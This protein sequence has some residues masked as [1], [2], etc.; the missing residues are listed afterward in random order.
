MNTHNVGVKND[1]KNL[2]LKNDKMTPK[3]LE[4]R[5]DPYIFTL[6]ETLVCVLQELSKSEAHV[7]RVRCVAWSPDSLR[8]VTGALDSN[9]ILWDD[10]N[11][12]YKSRPSIKGQFSAQSKVFFMMLTFDR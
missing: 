2:T 11:E 8:F 3:N 9:V 5:C 10:V 7:A 1:P 4:S 12:S 6:W